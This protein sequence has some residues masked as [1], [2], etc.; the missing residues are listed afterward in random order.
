MSIYAIVWA[1]DQEV[2]NSGQKFT[3]V[4]T[5]Q[6]CI[7]GDTA[8]VKQETLARDM[9]MGLSTVRRHLDNL[10]K[11]GVIQRKERWRQDGSRAPDWIKLVGFEESEN[12][13]RELNR[14][15]RA[16]SQPSTAAIGAQSEQDNRSN[17]AGTKR[18]TETSDSKNATRSEA[19]KNGKGQ[20]QLFM[21]EVC[22]A[23]KQHKVKLSTK[24]YEYNL[25]RLGLML[26][27]DELTIEE[28]E[29]LPEMAVEYYARWKKLDVR[30]ALMKERADQI[31]LP[32]KRQRKGGEKKQPNRGESEYTDYDDLTINR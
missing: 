19:R 6:Y 5:A 2:K 23:L 1:Y 14:S 18:G 17:Q 27:R 16:P 3:L 8:S 11:S 15:N 26:E 10:E 24:Q 20:R 22:G 31:E 4:T 32:P 30:D 9:S 13:R 28:I 25:G 12:R 29:R 21:D 7:D